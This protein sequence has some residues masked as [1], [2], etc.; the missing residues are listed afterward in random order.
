[1]LIASICS[2]WG[3][4][5]DRQHVIGHAEVPDPNNPGLYGGTEHHTDPG[6]YW[7]WTNYLDEARRAAALLPSPPHIGPA[8]SAVAENGGVLLSW[9]G[10]SCHN[11]ITSYDIV[12]SPAGIS[13]TLP[14]T[15]SYVWI[16]NLTNGASYTFTV[17]AH[18]S[19]GTATLTSNTAIPGP[20]CTTT[21]LST[22]TSSPQPV[23]TV[24]A[25]A[26]TSA[27]C[28]T[29]EYAFWVQPQGGAWSLER[30]YASS[31]RWGWDTSGLTPGVYELGVVAGQGSS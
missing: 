26:A 15:S 23:G 25:F 9:R 19:E 3:V 27:G 24:V 8:P 21:S 1:Q 17:T 5:L 4:P 30:D 28:N 11:P 10:H 16:P 18:N 31:S 13:M 29:A 14:G 12:S 7:D 22:G 2:R 6:P 20:R